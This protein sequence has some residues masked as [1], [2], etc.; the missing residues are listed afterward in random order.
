MVQF[1]QRTLLLAFIMVM[2]GV[3]ARKSYHVKEMIR[4]GTIKVHSPRVMASDCKWCYFKDANNDFCIEGDL[5]W[6]VESKTEQEYAAA[7]VLGV[8]PHYNHT[9][10]I[11]TT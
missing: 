7:T 10:I 5:N 1:I 11:Q 8:P 6:K 9:L 3:E 2:A 4:A